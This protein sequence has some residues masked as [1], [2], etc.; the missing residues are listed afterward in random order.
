MATNGMVCT[1]SRARPCAADSCTTLFFTLTTRRPRSYLRLALNTR[2]NAAFA[3]VF[4]APTRG[5]G[6]VGYVRVH[7]AAK[8]ASLS[9]YPSVMSFVTQLRLGGAGYGPTDADVLHE[10]G[11]GL[12]SLV[13]AMESL[14][15][16][17]SSH[18][19]ALASGRP[20]VFLVFS[21]WRVLPETLHRGVS[22]SVWRFARRC[23][24]LSSTRF[25]AF[26]CFRSNTHTPV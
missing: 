5:L 12:R 1:L 9:A 18:A 6:A 16:L 7:A 10:H 25:R 24:N 4:D 22:S 17:P 19:L 21:S 23:I 13:D 15:V 11:V 14:Q 26:I 2:D 20:E 8:R 3:R